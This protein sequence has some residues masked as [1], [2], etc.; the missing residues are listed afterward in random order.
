MQ[1]KF[2]VQCQYK[3]A[4]IIRLSNVTKFLLVGF[5]KSRRAQ[6]HTY[7]YTF[8]TTTSK[9]Y[10]NIAGVSGQILLKEI[11]GL[12]SPDWCGEGENAFANPCESPQAAKETMVHPCF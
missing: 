9:T 10:K 2:G 5:K 8:E 3:D 6:V 1:L 12:F 7:A 11:R 4:Y